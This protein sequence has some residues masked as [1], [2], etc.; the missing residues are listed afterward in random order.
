MEEKRLSAM[1]HLMA[2]QE[3]M[4]WTVRLKPTLDAEQTDEAV[5]QIKEAISEMLEKIMLICTQ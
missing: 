2:F 4:L 1:E 5:V 3:H